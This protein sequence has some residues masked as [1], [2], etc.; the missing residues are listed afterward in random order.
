MF[1]TNEIIPKVQPKVQSQKTERKNYYQNSSD[2]FDIMLSTTEVNL[3]R[4]LEN[5]K[6]HNKTETWNKLDRS[7][8][9]QK[10]NVFAHKYIVEI[11]IHEKYVNVLLAFF[12]DCL[13]RN[14][15]QNKK[16]LNYDKE[17]NEI[18][19]IPS[20]HFEPLNCTFLLKNIDKKR[21]STINSLTPK[22][23]SEKHQL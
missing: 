18:I 23:T 17:T 10:L 7:I 12:N 16:D 1:A 8:K 6:Q 15:L 9:I 14:K 19:T 3:D 5:E 22:R 21:V 13:V 20:L 4:I 2:M 11:G